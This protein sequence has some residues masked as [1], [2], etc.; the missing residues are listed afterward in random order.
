MADISLPDLKQRLRGQRASE[1]VPLAEMRAALEA[2]SAR[3]KPDPRVSCAPT[4]A[5]TR[6]AEWLKPDGA[7]PGAV[8]LYLH[9]GGFVGGSC[10]SHRPLAAA[11]ALASGIA[12]LTLDYRLAP[13]HPWPAAEDDVFAAYGHLLNEGYRVAVAGDSAGGNLAMRLL[14]R[15]READLPQPHA[16]ALFSPWIDLDL[17]SPSIAELAGADPTLTAG[18]LERFAALYRGGERGPQIL[19]ADLGGLP[20]I[21]LQAGG[22][23]ILRDDAARLAAGLMQAGSAASLEIWPGAF[24]VWHAFFPWLAE[25]RAAIA[26]AGAFLK[27]AEAAV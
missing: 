8:L 17:T 6:A 2:A 24:H 18:R 12:T 7:Q 22:D 15:L 20:P 14:L 11:L 25:A 4:R 13:E 1:D 16:M 23:E 9:G 5:G 26:R 21:L 10:A 27:Q 19:D 3:A